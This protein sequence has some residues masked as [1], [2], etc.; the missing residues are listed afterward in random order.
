MNNE[1]ENKI[2]LSVQN[3]KKIRFRMDGTPTDKYF[4]YH[5][6]AIIKDNFNDEI[7]I[8]GLIEKDYELNGERD[9]KYARPTLGSILE[10]Y[11][12]E[13]SFSPLDNWKNELKGQTIDYIVCVNE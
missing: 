6:Y 13:E 3:K 5:P 12:V 7:S 9:S 1:I 8:V 11:I 2:R 10:G 4:L